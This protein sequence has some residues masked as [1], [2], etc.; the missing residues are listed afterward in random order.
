[1]SF[2]IQSKNIFLTYSNCFKQNPDILDEFENMDACTPERMVKVMINK[3]MEIKSSKILMCYEK[4]ANQ[5]DFHFHALLQFPKKV[6]IKNERFFD[7]F[8]L[9]P[10]IEA[11]RSVMAAKTYIKKDGVFVSNYEEEESEET[12]YVEMAKETD[13]GSYLHYC[14]KKNLPF[15]YAD[16]FWKIA[17]AEADTTIEDGNSEGVYKNPQLDFIVIPEE[18]YKKQV[19]V[20]VGESGTG[21]TTWAIRNAPKPC[22]FVSHLDQL[23]RL[24]PRHKSII[25][26]DMNFTHIPREAQIQLVD[27]YMPR[28]IHVRYGVV[29]I[30]A[31][32]PKI[33][34]ANLYPFME[35]AAIN[36]R[37]HR[38]NLI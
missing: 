2:R 20:I 34:T 16:A 27:Q 15:S 30:P 37:V 14:M 12:D 1:M 13:R 38:I 9:H 25:F 23:K 8:G 28:A 31:G 35:D 24:T 26:D 5:S 29:T 18:A 6:D 4:H 10:S 7:L 32:L 33:F 22:L 3:L 19:V 36:R 21:K 17:H 11:C